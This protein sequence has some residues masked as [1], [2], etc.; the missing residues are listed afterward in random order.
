MTTPM[1]RPNSSPASVRPTA[2]D[3][4]RWFRT[5]GLTGRPVS[6]SSLAAGSAA[7]SFNTSDDEAVEDRSI[8]HNKRAETSGAATMA[9]RLMHAIA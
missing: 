3:G 8:V 9:A 6:A 7:A 5:A 1:M 4:V 2:V